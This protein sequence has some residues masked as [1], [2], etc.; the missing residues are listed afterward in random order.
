MFVYGGFGGVRTTA[1]NLEIGR[2][3]LLLDRLAQ[4]SLLVRKSRI[5]AR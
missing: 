3:L 2:L 4:K 5:Q 1:V